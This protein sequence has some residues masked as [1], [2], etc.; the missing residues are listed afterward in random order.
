MP[1]PE[2][3]RPLHYQMAWHPRLDGDLGQRRLRDAIR[4]VT[5]ELPDAVA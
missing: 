4:A 2:E 1:A 5:A 3:T